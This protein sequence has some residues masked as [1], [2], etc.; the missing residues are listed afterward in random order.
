MNCDAIVSVNCM[1]WWYTCVAVNDEILTNMTYRD[2]DC[3]KGTIT[4]DWSEL[5][6]NVFVKLSFYFAIRWNY[7]IISRSQDVLNMIL[8]HV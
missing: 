4:Y 8:L 3:P 5:F 1:Q 7:D 6:N 2:E